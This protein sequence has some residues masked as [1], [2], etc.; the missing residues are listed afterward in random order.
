MIKK[1][2]LYTTD[3]AFNRQVMLS[4]LEKIFLPEVKIY[5]FVPSENWKK[6]KVTR[7]KIVENSCTKYTSF[8]G[9]R[10][11]CKKEKIERIMNLGVLPQEGLVTSFAS[12]FTQADF[13]CQVVGN[14]TEIFKIESYNR[15]LKSSFEVL[16]LFP[17]AFLTKKILVAAKDVTQSMKRYLFP[18]KNKIFQL[19]LT[20]D[21][22][23]FV[24]KDK[25]K[26]RKKLN[27]PLNK[28]IVI[29]VGRIEFMKGSDILIEIAKK[30]K[31][32]LFYLVGTLN[33]KEI[34]VP[35]LSNIKV[36]SPKSSEE[37]VNYYNTSDLCFFPSRIEGFGLVPREAMSCGTPTLVSDITSLRL[38]EAA[39]KSPLDIEKMDRKIKDFFNLLDKEKKK[40]SVES[41]KF[42]IQECGANTYKKEYSRQLLS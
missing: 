5:L 10:R 28:K 32:I 3:F 22:D 15:N 34:R 6:Y 27:F 2:C 4:Y 23:L 9:L 29:Y 14:P 37:L 8:F 26:S 11:F 12:L 36:L 1:L 38:I 20:V 31:D 25:T 19:P 21:T 33:E 13:I 30:N 35:N 18:N 41:R 39:I 16:L 24:P 40:I 17:L 42:V 7:A